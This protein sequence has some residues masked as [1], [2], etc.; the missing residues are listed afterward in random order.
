MGRL[1]L[2]ITHFKY[3]YFNFMVRYKDTFILKSV[4]CSQEIDYFRLQ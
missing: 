2:I 3:F 1:H 4:K